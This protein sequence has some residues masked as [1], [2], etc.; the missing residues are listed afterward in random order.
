MNRIIHFN[1]SADDPRRTINFYGTVFGWK[2]DKWPGPVEYW[3]FATGPDDE[4]G[5]NG[6]I[7]KRDEP[8]DHFSSLVSDQ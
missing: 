6:G 2:A 7:G 1:I 4:P 8:G 5:I 3:T